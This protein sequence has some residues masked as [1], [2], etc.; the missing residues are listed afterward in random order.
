M[1]CYEVLPR[2]AVRVCTVTC[3]CSSGLVCIYTK[4]NESRS[5]KRIGTR[6]HLNP[7]L[8]LQCSNFADIFVAVQSS[9]C[10]CLYLSWAQ[11]KQQQQHHR[12]EETWPR[13]ASHR[14]NISFLCKCRSGSAGESLCTFDL[15]HGLQEQ[16]SRR[17]H[18]KC[19]TK[20]LQGPP[21]NFPRQHRGINTRHS[22]N[23]Q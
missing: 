20:T 2:S 16:V 18:L 6:N 15:T 14:V 22:L 1:C 19:C 7:S 9:R 17:Q 13:I 4:F 10:T 8:R 3:S 12:F 21:C 5:K 23:G 11:Q